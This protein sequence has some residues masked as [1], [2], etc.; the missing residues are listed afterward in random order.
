MRL[1]KPTLGRANLVTIDGRDVEGFDDPYGM[2]NINDANIINSTPY[3]CNSPAL[4]LPQ[5]FGY[6]TC[7]Y[8]VRVILKSSRAYFMGFKIQMNH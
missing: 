6:V 3:E 1:T 2:T 5:N 4:L 7:K 8:Y